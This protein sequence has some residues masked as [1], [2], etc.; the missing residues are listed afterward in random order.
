MRS[1]LFKTV[2]TLLLAATPFLAQAT[3]LDQLKNFSTMHAQPEESSARPRSKPEKKSA[4]PTRLPE[5]F[6]FRVRANSSGLTA[7]LMNRYCR[8]TVP[9]CTCTTRT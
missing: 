7:N 9:G 5:R 3:A 1:C 2:C 4:S 8:Q 6:F